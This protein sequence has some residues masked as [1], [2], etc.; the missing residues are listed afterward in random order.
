[1]GTDDTHQI[2]VN[3]KKKYFTKRIL[4]VQSW[5]W[6]AGSVNTVEECA[7]HCRADPNCGGWTYY[8]TGSNCRT[9]YDVESI[10]EPE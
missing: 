8:P 9:S 7:D 2:N 1:M 6:Y 5:Q 3:H 10:W 4:I